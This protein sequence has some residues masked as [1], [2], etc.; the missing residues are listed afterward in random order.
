MKPLIKDILW[1]VVGAA[2]GSGITALFLKKRYTAT[3]QEELNNIMERYKKMKEKS[4]NDNTEKNEISEDPIIKEYIDYASQYR[5]N[6]LDEEIEK[7]FP[8]IDIPLEIELDKPYVIT[9]EEFGEM[10][11]YE[12]VS[13]TYYADDFLTDDQNYLIEDILDTVGENALS[14]FGEYEDDSVYIRNDKKK[15]DYEILL[16]EK[17][18]K[19]VLKENPHLMDEMK[20]LGYKD[21]E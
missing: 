6:K 20:H 12:T 14:H 9:P 7:E 5:P 21:L 2:I 18:Y 8:N 19:D 1:F 13:L 4:L 17:K 3:T 15:C 10:Y 11:D 16:S